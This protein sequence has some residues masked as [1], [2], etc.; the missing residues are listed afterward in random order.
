MKTFAGLI[1]VL[2]GCFGCASDESTQEM[3]ADDPAH[4]AGIAYDPVTHVEVR[5]DSPW[6]SSWNGAWYYFE[7]SENKMRFDVNPEAYVVPDPRTKKERRK[8]YPY[9]AQ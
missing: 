8:V 7:S 4:P 3:A 5:T 2:L 6:K 1:L 9:Q